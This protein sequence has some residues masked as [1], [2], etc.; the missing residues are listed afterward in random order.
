[1]FTEYVSNSTNYIIIQVLHVKLSNKINVRNPHSVDKTHSLQ[2]KNSCLRDI[3]ND[4][5]IF[6]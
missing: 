5:I 4:V 1:M 6:H 3:N 2:G